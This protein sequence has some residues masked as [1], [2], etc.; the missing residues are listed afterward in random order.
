MKLNTTTEYAL[1]ILIYMAKKPDE[2]FHTKE[3]SETL[4]ISYKYMTKIITLLSNNQII[5][6]KKGKYGGIILNKK[7]DD[8]TVKE[9]LTIMNDLDDDKCILGLGLCSEKNKCSM[10]EVWME[11]KNS[12]IHTFSQTTLESLAKNQG[13]LI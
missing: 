6:S 8:I 12:I 4:N 13:N 10:H 11:S 9:I 2:L 7:I 5:S 1:R 3:I